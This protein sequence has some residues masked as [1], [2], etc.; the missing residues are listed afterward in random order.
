MHKSVAAVGDAIAESTCVS[1]HSLIFF[2]VCEQTEP[3]EL[4]NQKQRFGDLVAL[5]DKPC[6]VDNCNLFFLVFFGNSLQCVCVCL[7]R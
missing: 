6:L 4:L 1:C 5:V 2:A 7:D 3:T